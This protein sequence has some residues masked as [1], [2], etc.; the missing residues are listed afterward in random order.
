M[1]AATKNKMALAAQGQGTYPSLSVQVKVPC[2]NSIEAEDRGAQIRHGVGTSAKGTAHPVALW[3]GGALRE[4]QRRGWRQEEQEAQ[5]N[6]KR[7]DR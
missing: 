6:K 7:L 3:Q 4:G 5:D 2:A 1:V